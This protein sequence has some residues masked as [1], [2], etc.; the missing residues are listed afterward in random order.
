MTQIKNNLRK[1]SLAIFAMIMLTSCSHRITDFTIISSKNIDL[2]RGAEFKRAHVRSSGID[3]VHVIAFFPT[4][5][6]NAKE[7][8]DRAIEGTNGAVALLDGVIVRHS[9]YIPAIYG[10]EWIEVE[11]TA[12]IDPKLENK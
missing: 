9:W 11:G 12:L 1:S 2:S 7:A 3:K 6:P 5:I 10:Q 8:T 4:G